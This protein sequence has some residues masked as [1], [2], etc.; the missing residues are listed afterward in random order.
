[1][2]EHLVS[3][4]EHIQLVIVLRH[5]LEGRAL[6]G[7]EPPG[8]SALWGTLRGGFSGLRQD[9]RLQGVVQHNP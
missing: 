1:M 3:V 2:L 8:A 4:G 7:C 6:P 9:T 5:L